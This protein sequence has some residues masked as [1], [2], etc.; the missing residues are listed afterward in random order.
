MSRRALAVV[1]IAGSAAFVTLVGLLHALEPDT[2]DSDAISEYALGDYGLLMNAAFFSAAAAFAALALALR[3]SLAPTTSARV[4][5]VLLCIA[6]LGWF[7]LGAGNIDPEG[8]DATWHGVVHGIGFFLTTPA[9]IASLF[10]L[11]RAFRQ[12]ERWRPFR[13]TVLAAAVA[14]LVLFA[15]AFSDVA[16]ALTFR[17]YVVVVLAAVV[18]MAMRIRSFA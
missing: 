6:A 4:A 1:A 7:L 2:N 11:A 17:L 10:V 13:R 16:S 18:A 12:D 8:A 9:V 3:R 15:L 14:A 5:V